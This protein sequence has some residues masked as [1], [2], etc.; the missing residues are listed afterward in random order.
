MN[1][2]PP[3]GKGFAPDTFAVPDPEPGVP[4][5]VTTVT[6]GRREAEEVV[7][8]DVDKIVEAEE[9]AAEEEEEAPEE[10]PAASDNWAKPIEAG[11]ERKTEY[12]FF[13]VVF[14]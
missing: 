12:T 5:M 3:V 14:Y 11:L 6:G 2:P 1:L 10:P 13:W 7:S 8:V 4:V 9:A